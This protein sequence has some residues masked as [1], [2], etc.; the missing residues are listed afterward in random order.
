[1]GSLHIFVADDQ[2]PPSDVPE[3]EFRENLLA[4]YGDTQQNRGFA[5]Q[6]QFMREIVKGLRDS[7]YQVTAASTYRDAE[8]EISEGEFDLAIIDLGWY[9]DFSLREDERGSAGWSLC[10]LLDDKDKRTGKLTPQILFSSRFPKEPELSQKAAQRQK[11]PMF[12]EPTET[13]RN[14]LM[15]AVGFVEATLSA[16]RSAGSTDSGYFVHQLQSIALSLFKE[17][18]QNYRRWSFLTLFFVAISL[19]L[20]V[21]GVVHAYV[22]KQ[23]VDYVSSFSSLLSSAISALLF[24]Q[25][26]SAQAALT[27]VRGEVLKQLTERASQLSNAA[28][29]DVTIGRT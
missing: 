19:A 10:D 16:Q 9:M 22:Q 28:P 7:G 2:I 20:L 12:K 27:S 24:K 11:L 17:P 5:K 14:S 25:A 18:L 6:C 1:M 3:R 4:K 29:R 21:A 23:P 13:V 26:R 8:K 15:A